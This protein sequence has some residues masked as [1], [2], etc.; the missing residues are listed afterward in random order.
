MSEVVEPVT[1]LSLFQVFCIKSVV[2]LGS[3]NQ[4]SAYVPQFV[5]HVV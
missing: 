1:I 4:I 3:L 2:F 5:D